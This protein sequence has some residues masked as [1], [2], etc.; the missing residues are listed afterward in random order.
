MDTESEAEIS[1]LR[2]DNARLRNERDAFR[3][4]LQRALDVNA[5]AKAKELDELI[6]SASSRIKEDVLAWLKKWG[7]LIAGLA[8]IATAGGLLQFKDYILGRV[9]T[10]VTGA[11]TNR[12]NAEMQTA[13]RRLSSVESDVEVTRAKLIDAVSDFKAEAKQALREIENER[14]SVVDHASKTREAISAEFA[15]TFT[16]AQGVSQVAVS[17]AA[18]QGAGID[19]WFGTLPPNVVAIAGSQADQQASDDGGLKMGLFSAHFQKALQDRSADANGDGTISW[20]EAVAVAERKMKAR[21]TRDQLPVIAGNNASEGLFVIGG[22]NEKPAKFKSTRAL[23]IGINEY[24]SGFNLQ[25]AVNDVKGMQRILEGGSASLAGSLEV[26]MI[27]DRRATRA[28]IEAAI[29]KLA[30]A[31]GPNDLCL[32]YYSG[33][34]LT[35]STNTGK[36]EKGFVPTDIDSKD[37][38]GISVPKIIQRLGQAKGQSVVII[39]G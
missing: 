39:D 6:I 17:V 31:T 16:S 32:V 15:A 8:S 13:K 34:V 30:A 37:Y 3:K 25:N 33:H 28:A 26:T 38:R 4:D 35:T 23:L 10:E 14:Q 7:V 11:V 27:L 21:P 20:R 9:N 5:T 18:P 22:A 29:E 1:R 19:V 2:E 24:K 12:V 36:S